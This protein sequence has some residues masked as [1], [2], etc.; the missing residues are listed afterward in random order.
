MSNIR[1]IFI[2]LGLVLALVATAV[3]GGNDQAAAAGETDL[4]RAI[5]AQEANTAA[6]MAIDGVI[7]TAVGQGSGGGHIVLAL[8]E[9][10]GVT[11]IPGAVDGVVVRPYVTGE[12]LAQPKPGSTP[13]VDPTARFERPVPIGVSTGHPS[14]TAGTIGARVRDGSGNLFALSN[15]H[16]Y[17][18]ENSASIGAA[19]IQPGTYDGGSSP[20][21]NIGTLSD[22]EPISFSSS[23]IM[24]AA[25]ASVTSATLG[26]STPDGA[27]YGAPSST[28]ATALTGMNV[29]KYGRATGETN[30]RVDAINASVNVAYDSGTALFVGQ[31]IIKGRKG[32]F[33]AGGDSGS[34]IVTKDGSNPVA[35]L[36]AGNSTVTI[37]NPIDAVLS[38]FNVTIDD[39][40]A[41]PAPVDTGSISGQVLDSDTGSGLAGAIVATDTGQT[42]TTDGSGN[43]SLADV[44]VGS[45]TVTASKTAYESDSTL[46]EV[47]KD[48]NEVASTLTLTPID[49]GILTVSSIEFI[50]E[51]R[52]PHTDLV[53]TV[54][55]V[56]KA[57]L[58]SPISGANV[59][60]TLSRP[61][62]SWN[63]SGSTNSS[64]QFSGKLRSAIVGQTYTVVVNGVTHSLFV[65]D[66][67]DPPAS[68][69]HEVIG[70]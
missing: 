45:R 4:G 40:N 39:G 53:F 32:S 25:I 54:T 12:I 37:A 66:S 57:D 42:T 69:S 14:I 10:G 24:D 2:A 1:R 41:P 67:P 9:R 46:V 49:I 31:V 5:A 6:L 23:N 8:T 59:S 3:F 17:A 58:L 11:G 43:Y 48:L 16:V 50:E 52:G 64:G 27:G 21:D 36:F 7:G 13:D 35:L 30:G 47:A 18:D 29:T 19:V 70:Q 65:Y 68:E 51:A 34:L 38:R 60:T 63:I 61:G 15:N 56:D 33:S 55:I 22:Y 44:P 62:A 28:T 20:A 26:F